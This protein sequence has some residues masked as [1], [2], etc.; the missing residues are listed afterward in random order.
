M[1]IKNEYE[2]IYCMLITKQNTTCGYS[3]DGK[4][5]LPY[6]KEGKI[7]GRGQG[8]EQTDE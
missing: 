6:N 5:E 3:H 1:Y 2:F 8:V 7:K 4:G